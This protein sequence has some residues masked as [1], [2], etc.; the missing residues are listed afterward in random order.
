[1][2]LR[3]G[4][5]LLVFDVPNFLIRPPSHIGDELSKPPIWIPLA[6][7]IHSRKQFRALFTIHGKTSFT[8]GIRVTSSFTNS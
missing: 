6:Q 1:M 5:E 8:L 7:L 2:G 3:H 4:E